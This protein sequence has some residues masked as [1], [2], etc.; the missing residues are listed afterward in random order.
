MARVLS[1]WTSRGREW[2][3]RAFGKADLSM[4]KGNPFLALRLSHD[5]QDALRA[6]AAASGLTP[7]DL[8]RQLLAHHAEARRSHQ[9]I[10]DAQPRKPTAA[11]VR[12]PRELSRPVRMQRALSILEGLL[13]DYEDWQTNLPDSLQDSATGV[14]LAEAIDNLQQAVDLLTATTLPRGFG[15]D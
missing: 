7:S 10:P 9:E 8:V 2:L 14:A 11:P 4:S 5:Q 1:P 6:N 15:R 13:A 3:R 12:R